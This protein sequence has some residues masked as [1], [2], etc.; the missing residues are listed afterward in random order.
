MRILAI[1][2]LHG[3]PE[4]EI[5]L[6][7]NTQCDIC[8]FLGDIPRPAIQQIS[9]VIGNVPMIG[10]VGNHDE[11]NELEETNVQHIHLKRFEHMGVSFAG[12]SGSERYKTGNYPMLTQ[13]ESIRLARDIPKADIL[14]SHDCG[15]HILN[16]KEAHEGLKGI[17]S[18]CFW[19]RCRLNICGHHHVD[20]IEKRWLATTI[21]I[22]GATIINYPGI[23]T[24]KIF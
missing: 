15:Y 24:T 9:S 3:C 13:S 6:L 4:K 16:K 21:C 2:D 5:Q 17:S 14:I 10:V 19:N 8:V 1:A 18:Y 22:Y 12:L 7:K 23:T 11:W 20:K